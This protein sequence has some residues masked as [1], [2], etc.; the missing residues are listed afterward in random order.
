MPIRKKDGLDRIAAVYLIATAAFVIGITVLSFAQGVETVGAPNWA[1][2]V[3]AVG[4][5]AAIAIS[6]LLGDRDHTA[7]L[8]GM[9]I[10]PLFAI[11][12]VGVLGIPSAADSMDVSAVKAMQDLRAAR[13]ISWML[14]LVVAPL[15]MLVVACAGWY[16]KAKSQS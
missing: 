16:E 6:Q 12:L 13:N 11:A 9:G 7:T 15:I 1:W 5:L 10:V 2:L 4:L 3:W 8:L 14:A